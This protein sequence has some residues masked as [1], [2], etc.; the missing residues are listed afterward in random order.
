V[1]IR[2]DPADP[3][4]VYEQIRAQIT[5]MAAIGTLPEGTRLPTIRQLASDLGLA[6]GTIAKAYEELDRDG[7]IV[8][9]G[10]SGSFIEAPG[11]GGDRLVES[12]LRNAAESFAVVAVQVGA[13]RDTAVAAVDEA[14]AAIGTGEIAR[15]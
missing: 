5:T 13:D 7:V 2:V 14:W 6:K 11:A 9:R 12:R 3:T 1:I 4:P 15:T 10:R 8:T